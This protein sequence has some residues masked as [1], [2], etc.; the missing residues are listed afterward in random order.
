[1]NVLQLIKSNDLLNEQVEYI[2][3]AF[4]K[5]FPEVRFDDRKEI[6][7]IGEPDRYLM[8]YFFY[9]DNTFYVKF[10]CN[11]VYTVLPQDFNQV[12]ACV[13]KTINLFKNNEFIK[14]RKIKRVYQRIGFNLYD[15]E[16]NFSRDINNI[17]AEYLLKKE[18]FNERA[19]ELSR[20]LKLFVESFIQDDFKKDVVLSLALQE[21]EYKTL[22]EL[23]VKYE[24]FKRKIYSTFRK[25]LKII[26]KRINLQK[27]EYLKLYNLRNEFMDKFSNCC[28]D[29]FAIYLHEHYNAYFIRAF[30]EIFIPKKYNHDDIIY[31]INDNRKLIKQK[32][33]VKKVDYNGFKVFISGDGEFVTDLNLLDKLIVLRK[34]F[35]SENGALEKWIYLDMQLVILATEKPTTQEEFY[36][37]LNTDKGWQDFGFETVEEIKNHLNNLK[38]KTYRSIYEKN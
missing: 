16:L 34:R 11:Q 24:I 26:S 15:I 32:S 2:F 7:G 17:K 19:T 5:E 31:S 35:A 22:K 29:A 6:L 12:D 1:M 21:G 13:E 33:R 9:R 37:V 27:E 28:I 4:S 3:S 20:L 14:Q 8:C 18:E 36:K 10:K 30:V 25:Q 38:L 23:S